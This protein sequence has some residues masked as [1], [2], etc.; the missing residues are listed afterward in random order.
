MVTMPT[1]ECPEHGWRSPEEVREGQ[2]VECGKAVEVGPL[3]AMSKSKRNTVDPEA[4]VARFG[5]DTARVFIL[6]ASPPER[7]LEWSETGVDGAHR[8]L[9]RVWR[10]VRDHLDV[11]KK[12]SAY[13]GDGSDLGEP[14]RVLRRRTHT[15]ILRVT[16]DIGEERQLNT[17]IAA[18]MELL[19]ALGAFEGD[20]PADAAVRREAVEVLVH[21]LFPFAPH[22]CDELWKELG[23]VATLLEQPWPR[24]DA[25]AAKEDLVFIPVQVNGKVRGRVQVPAGADEATVVAASRALEAVKALLDDRATHKYV[26]GRIIN[27]VVPR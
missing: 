15:T 23:G 8:F 27:F 17:A 5:A 19:N 10:A 21:L 14:A 7:E 20:Q 1:L 11:L 13:A 12:T 16:R 6:F 3:R 22:L 18:I 9:S 2:C 24:F 26:P 4:L 25:A